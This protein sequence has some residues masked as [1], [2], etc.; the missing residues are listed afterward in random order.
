MFFLFKKCLGLWCNILKLIFQ[1]YIQFSIPRWY[2]FV[3]LLFNFVFIVKADIWFQVFYG[4]CRIK[5]TKR[6]YVLPFLVKKVFFFATPSLSCLAMGRVVKSGRPA[7]PDLTCRAKLQNR[8]RRDWLIY[9]LGHIFHS[10]AQPKTHR[11]GS[12]LA[13]IIFKEKFLKVLKQHIKLW[14]C[15]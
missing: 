12:G 11:T 15:D 7:Q 13:R 5:L 9:Y 14:V 6:T 4:F 2:G 3:S 10:L 1:L 8:A